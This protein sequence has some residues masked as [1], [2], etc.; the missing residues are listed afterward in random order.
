[1]T[2]EYLGAEHR[3]AVAFLVG[4]SIDEQ[5]AKQDQAHHDR[6][7]E[8]ETRSVGITH[9]AQHNLRSS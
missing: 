3:L 6:D 8:I 1:V 7:G 4:S 9:A 5:R 2:P